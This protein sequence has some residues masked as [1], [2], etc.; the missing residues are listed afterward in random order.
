M[1]E[2]DIITCP[3]K[4]QIL[5]EYQKNYLRLRNVNLVINKTVF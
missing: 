2:I 5:N 4:K 1:E 3:K